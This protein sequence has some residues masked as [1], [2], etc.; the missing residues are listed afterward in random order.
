MYNEKKQT[1]DC[2]EKILFSI[3]LFQIIRN[4]NYFLY[5]ILFYLIS[6]ILLILYFFL[7]FQLCNN[8]FF[9]RINLL[10]CLILLIL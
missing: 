2:I 4:F 3:N 8:D 5:F 6:F 9:I 10:K 7:L 1:V